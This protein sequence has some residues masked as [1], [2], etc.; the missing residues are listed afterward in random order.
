MSDHSYDIAVS[1]AG[2][3]REYVER[4]VRECQ[5]RSL[6]VFYDRDMTNDWWGGNFIREQRTVYSSKTRYFVPLLSSDYLSKEIPM[7]EFSSAMMT[8]VKQGDGYILPVLMDDA[9]IPP[10]LLHP[11]I[12]YIRANDYTP[13]Q[14]AVELEK[15]VRGAE[16]SGQSTQPIGSVVEKALQVRMPKIV[17]EDWSKYGALDEIFEYLGKRFKEGAEQLRSQRLMTSVK[18]GDDKIVIRVERMGETVAGLNVD[19]GSNIGDD[20][21][22]WLTGIQNFSSNGFNGWATPKFDKELG[23]GVIEV[24]DMAGLGGGHQ[25][26]LSNEQFFSALWEMLVTQI[27]QRSS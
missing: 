17:P 10:D 23:R 18:A 19:K 7:D 14:L 11:H 12:G 1:F 20:H 27:E 9:P 24:S 4:V 3:Q 25:G 26:D 22:T 8:A 16:R 5:E 6:E 21:I 15:K 2:E 13:A